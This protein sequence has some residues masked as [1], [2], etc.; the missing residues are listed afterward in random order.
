MHGVQLAVGYQL[1]L[2]TPRPTVKPFAWSRA[3]AAG[4]ATHITRG[5]A[6]LTS[7]AFDGGHA[8]LYLVND[9]RTC[10]DPPTTVLGAI[11]G[12]SGEIVI[13]PGSSVC[14]RSD[15]PGTLSVTGYR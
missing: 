1:S 13:P 7:Y 4:D 2:H 14:T 12:I 15:G 9:H 8:K 3:L 6:R 5:P 11:P 10:Q